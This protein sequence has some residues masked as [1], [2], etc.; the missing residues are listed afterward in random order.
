MNIIAGEEPA[1]YSGADLVTPFAGEHLA[2]VEEWEL[3]QSDRTAAELDQDLG[4]E[5]LLFEALMDA[6][7]AQ[8][9]GLILAS[10]L[11]GSGQ[12]EAYFQARCTA[13]QVDAAM[14]RAAEQ[15]AAARARYA[16]DAVGVAA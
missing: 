11:L 15:L 16:V 9:K 7:D 8:E 12:F 6:M 4:Y 14:A 5:E 13:E 2:V 10:P 3:V 1:A